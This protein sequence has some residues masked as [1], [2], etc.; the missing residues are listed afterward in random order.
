M[1]FY[2]VSIVLPSHNCVICLFS[3][4]LVCQRHLNICIRWYPLVLGCIMLIIELLITQFELWHFISSKFN[5][6][7]IPLAFIFLSFL[8]QLK[9]CPNAFLAQLCVQLGCVLR[10]SSGSKQFLLHLFLSK[11]L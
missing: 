6:F 8:N 4:T 11:C 7:F 3:C 5:F 2:L 1:S 10:L 9:V